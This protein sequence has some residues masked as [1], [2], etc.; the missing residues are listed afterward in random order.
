VA[1][2]KKLLIAIAAIVVIAFALYFGRYILLAAF[3]S[4]VL[5]V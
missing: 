5:G 3:N 1:M 2:K 4:T